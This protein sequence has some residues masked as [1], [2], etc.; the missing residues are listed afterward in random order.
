MSHL[1]Y[2]SNSDVPPIV[3]GLNTLSKGVDFIELGWTALTHTNAIDYYLVFAN[4]NYVGSPSTN[5][6][7]VS[8]LTTATSY[9]FKIL[10]VDEMGNTYK[11][12]NVFT[13][14]TT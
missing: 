2:S 4:G 5:S 10:A 13:E 8:G 14:T 12:S 9:D 7:N 6:L 11:F 3:T 1:K